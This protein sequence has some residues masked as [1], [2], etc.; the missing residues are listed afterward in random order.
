MLPKLDVSHYFYHTPLLIAVR[1]MKLLC[2]QLNFYKNE[3]SDWDLFVSI[4]KLLIAQAEFTST[5]IL[6]R[7]NAP[8]YD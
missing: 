4:G 7:S 6:M 2:F 8:S 3:G 5:G 1:I